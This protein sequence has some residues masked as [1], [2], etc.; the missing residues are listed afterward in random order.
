MKNYTHLSFDCYGTLINWEQG[1]LNFFKPFC[2]EKNIEISDVE[3]LKI[4]ALLEAEEEHGDYQPYKEILKKVLMHFSKKFNVEL[5]SSEENGLAES[6][7]VWPVF[8][9][10][11]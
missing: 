9:D 7:K 8:E 1:I 4:Y 2:K 5:F 6:V 10:T 3:I 11:I